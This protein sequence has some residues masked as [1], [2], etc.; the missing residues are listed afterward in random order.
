[1]LCLDYNLF[2]EWLE[3]MDKIKQ[4][5]HVKTL[6]RYLNEFNRLRHKHYVG[7]HLNQNNHPQ[8]ISPHINNDN[9]NNNDKRDI[10]HRGYNNN[11][12]DDTRSKW[13]VNMFSFPFM[14]VQSSLLAREPKFTVFPRNPPKGESIAS[15]EE[16]W[17]CLPPRVALELGANTSKLLDKTHPLAQHH[18]S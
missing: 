5:R 2:S 9:I 10:N 16:V 18:P 3:F 17:L 11:N 15:V 14:E 6:R 7:T 1:M 12:I 4:G 8:Y 13:V